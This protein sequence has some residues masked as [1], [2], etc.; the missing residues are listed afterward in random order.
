MSEASQILRNQSASPKLEGQNDK[1][2]VDWQNLKPELIYINFLVGKFLYKN[3]FLV[4]KQDYSRNLLPTDQRRC[5]GHQKFIELSGNLVLRERNQWDE[6][7]IKRFQWWFTWIRTWWLYST[8]LH[9]YFP[10]PIPLLRKDRPIRFNSSKQSHY[11]WV[12]VQIRGNTC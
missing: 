7:I 12:F 6:G 4:R 11:S 2:F 1:G 9:Y 10:S 5:A 8:W 3:E